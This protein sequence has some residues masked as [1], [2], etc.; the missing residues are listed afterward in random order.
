MTAAA[1]PIPLVE[2]TPVAEPIASRP[3]AAEPSAVAPSTVEHAVESRLPPVQAP[4]AMPAP[5]PRPAAEPIDASRLQ[6]VVREAGLQW[7]QT[8]AGDAAAEPEPV[9]VTPRVPRVRQPRIRAASEPLVQV[10]TQPP[11][12]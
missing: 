9:V 5:V 3:F 2:P 4:S 8:T 11:R 7:V 1:A 6:E 12:E 10:E